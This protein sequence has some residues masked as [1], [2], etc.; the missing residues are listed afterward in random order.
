MAAPLRTVPRMYPVVSTGGNSV[1]QEDAPLQALPPS[2][3]NLAGHT[4]CEANTIIDEGPPEGGSDYKEPSD[5]HQ[6]DLCIIHYYRLTNTLNYSAHRLFHL[7][8]HVISA[9]VYFYDC[10]AAKAL[11]K[12]SGT[13][14]TSLAI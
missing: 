4:R 9:V 1:R 12:A 14:A 8:R 6:R 11:R 7:L 10:F 2:G 3:D 13:G 5:S